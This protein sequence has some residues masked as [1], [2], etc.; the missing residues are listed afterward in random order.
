VSN[1]GDAGSANG[2][3]T[4]VASLPPETKVESTYK[5]PVS[6]RNVV[7]VAN[8]T[9]GRVAYINAQTFDVQT[10]EAGDGPTYLAA[11]ADPTD[12]VAIVQ[13]VLSQNATLLR[14]HPG[15]TSPAATAVFP[16]TADANS[17]AISN[18]GRWAI[19]W[20][21]AAQV[22][23]PNPAQG[24]Q[25][26]AVIDTTKPGQSTILAVG[27]RPSAI[28]YS[29]D[30]DAYAVTDDGITEI[31][32]SGAQ[33]AV[34]RNFPLVFQSVESADGAVPGPDATPSIGDSGEAV[35]AGPDAGEAGIA[36]DASPA[37]AD[38]DAA[39]AVVPP[40]AA[41]TQPDVSFT[42]DGAYA[43]VRS[44]GVA[45]INVISL[46]DGVSSQVLLPALPTDLSIA[47]DGS[48]AVAVLRDTSTVAIL[49]LPGVVTN[50]GALSTIPVPGHVIGRG[51]VSPSGKSV[52]L[53]TTAAP[54]DEL[55]VL[56]LGANPSLYTATLH[57]PVLAVFP[58]ADGQN[59]LVLHNVTPVA[60]SNVLG[61]YSMVPI[62][63]QLPAFIVSLAAAP[64]A[65]ALA[66]TS[67]RALVAYRDDPS[68]TYGVDMVSIPSFQVTS[69]SLASA[70]TA[71]GIVTGSSAGGDAG[72][73]ALS[74]GYVG[75]DYADGRI[76][77]VDMSD[78]AER[79]ITG[80]ELSAQIVT[81]EG[82]GL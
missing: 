31:D 40:Q 17:W 24:F 63:Q 53:F 77:F 59:A 43:L 58:T 45:S 60:G 5:T 4:P 70:P 25:Q 20:T 74:R 71:V 32:L 76:T 3:G 62:A 22:T 39:V 19:A 61:A 50:P 67:D 15:S 64:L 18:S 7:W 27:Y 79:T 65:V 73:S 2:A 16:S 8:P 49:P 34:T 55:S 57:D 44:D 41:A 68:T 30:G 81:G 80:F 51:I 12:D 75:Q 52:L 66:P 48:F 78:G 37:P 69:F 56:T 47:P 54:V 46:H 1:G 13:N 26:L 36:A 10:V 9:S 11:V 72:S 35:E 33:P 42:P 6:T 21:N 38:A 23:S 28:A 14:V 82:G 29:G